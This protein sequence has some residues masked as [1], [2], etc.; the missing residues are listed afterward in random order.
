MSSSNKVFKVR[1]FSDMLMDSRWFSKRWSLVFV[2]LYDIYVLS[3][4]K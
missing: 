1:M 3:S 4:F 2:L